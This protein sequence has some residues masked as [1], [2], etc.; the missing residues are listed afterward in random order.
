M[1]A[2][3][4]YLEKLVSPTQTVDGTDIA[5]MHEAGVTRI[6]IEEATL[7]AFAYQVLSRLAD[8]L[9]FNLTP[10]ENLASSG[11]F[12]Y[13]FGYTTSSLPG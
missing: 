7:I 8:A 3:L 13:K 10:E 4:G 6:G 12:L 5:R 9:D 11:R 2:T 1:R